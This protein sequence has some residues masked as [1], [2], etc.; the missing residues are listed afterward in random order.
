MKNNK[1]LHSIVSITLALLFIGLMSASVT[2]AETY[3]FVTKWGS[4]GSGDGQF[5]AP[6]D[7]AIDSSNNVYVTD[8]GN[9]RIEKFDSNGNFITKW[10]SFGSSNGQFSTPWAIAIDSS[11]NIY[12]ADQNNF[13][14]QKFD[15]NGNY[16][17]QFG[18]FGTGDGQL[19]NPSGVAVDSSGNVFV[20]D[21]Y[22]NRVEKFSG[23]GTFLI[24][25]G[26]E[27]SADGQFRGLTG[28]AVDSSGNV[29]VA[30]TYNR[31]IQKFDNNGAFITKWG[32]YGIIDGKFSYPYD[33]TV[34]SSG[35]VYAVDRNDNDRIQKFDSNGNFITK[36]G[37]YG[38][39]DGLFHGPTGVAVDL[40]G[41]VYVA[42]TGNN[43]I[44]KFSKEKITPTITWNIPA[45][46]TAG[47]ALSS[48]QLNAAS[49]VQGT[50]SYSP[51]AGTILDVGTHTLHVVFTPSDS[52]TYNTASADIQISVLPAPLKTPTI[53]WDVPADIT[54]G[55]ALG[56]E[57]LNAV[58][59]DPVSGAAIGG[60]F[61]YN[62]PEGTELGVGTHK[63]Y[64]DFTPADAAKYTSVSKDVTINVLEK[65]AIP[66]AN[67]WATPITG[68][69]P[70]QVQFTDKSTGVPTSW[71]W[72]FGDKST[73]IDKNP[74]HQ[75][76]KAGKYTVSLTVKN[77]LGSNTRKI[78]NYIIVKK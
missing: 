39:D 32:S 61:T 6:Y 71:L 64:V 8:V 13:R 14:I 77:E 73:S 23:D 12:V 38:T 48:T 68:K 7:V 27:G 47:T 34:D 30:D 75:Y 59:T 26:S 2:H 67:F 4:S 62:P 33:V 15:S 10:G 19:W 78:N 24:K 20:A 36:W 69:V 63:L 49:T 60:I 65:P 53:T 70:L 29:Y 50:F 3:T 21:T 45:D 72:N 28:V 35:N 9:H 55:T 18:S 43:R 74:V 66:S 25:W 40:S 51:E 16:L 58:A 5:S 31:R 22:N 54:A 37:S 42:D 17:T 76:T 57:Q 46:I 41:N 1:N 56:S 44:Q 52:T 11:D